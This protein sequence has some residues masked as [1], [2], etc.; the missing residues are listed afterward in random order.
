MEDTD[1]ADRSRLVILKASRKTYGLT[2]LL[3]KLHQNDCRFQRYVC[4]SVTQF[5]EIF[6]P[7]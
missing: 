6:V 5:D 7:H 1:D 2:R 3:L 4:L